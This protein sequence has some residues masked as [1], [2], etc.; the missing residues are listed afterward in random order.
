[1]VE[2]TDIACLLVYCWTHTV[3]SRWT[4]WVCAEVS[5]LGLITTM[6]TEWTV[7]KEGKYIIQ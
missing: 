5:G 2:C 4:V 3:E 7:V 1:M 6:M